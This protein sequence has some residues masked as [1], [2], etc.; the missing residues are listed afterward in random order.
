MESDSSSTTNPSTSKSTI[1]E[2]EVISDAE[3]IFDAVNHL[4]ELYF[5]SN[6]NNESPTEFLQSQNVGRQIVAEIFVA[7][8]YREKFLTR[9]AKR[10]KLKKENTLTIPYLCFHLY[11]FELDM[12]SLPDILEAT[13]KWSSLRAQKILF[14]LLDKDSFLELGGCNIN[15]ESIIQSKSAC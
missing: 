5:T 11:M 12:D 10:F 2:P 3:E 4:I 9:L 14:F 6:V 8:M 7:A 13:S 15:F 1:N